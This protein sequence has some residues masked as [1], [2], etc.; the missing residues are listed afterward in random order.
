MRK[1]IGLVSALV[2]AVSIVLFFLDWTIGIGSLGVAGFVLILLSVV[3]G[4]VSSAVRAE[5]DVQDSTSWTY[6]P[7]E[8]LQ[9]PTADKSQL[10]LG[11]YSSGQR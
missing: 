5:T 1:Y 6:R 10:P 3:T 2:G 11:G 9:Q 8:G 7:V 4:L